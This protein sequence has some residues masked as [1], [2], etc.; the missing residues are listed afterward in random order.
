ME[1][2][3]LLKKYRLIQHKSQQSWVGN[4]VSRSF[5]TKVEQGK[6]HLSANDLL[7]L[8]HYNHIPTVDFFTKLNEVDRSQYHQKTQLKT[9]IT[10]AFYQNSKSKLKQIAD[11]IISSNYPNQEEQIAL[12]NAYIAL[13]NNDFDSLDEKSRSYLKEK[14]LNTKFLS[15]D[16]LTIYRNL[17][18]LFELD[19]NIAIVKKILNKFLNI[20]EIDIQASLIVILANITFLCVESQNYQD[21]AYFIA[22]ADK[23]NTRPDNFFYKMGILL[24][25]NILAYHK[26]SEESYLENCQ[27]I[28]KITKLNGMDAYS[29]ELEVYLQNNI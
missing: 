12:I 19:Q 11:K 17:I 13:V 7:D 9:L 27:E 6:S 26:K 18:P 4:I 2:Y 5:Y 15:K 22:C 24:S 10:N 16:Y 29:H 23:I 1:I 14:F 21:A 8:L 20:N 28:I 25:K 3:E